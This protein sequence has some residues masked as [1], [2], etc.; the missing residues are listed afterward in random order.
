MFPR[1]DPKIYPIDDD[2]QFAYELLAEEKVLIVQGTGF[3]WP[4]PDHFRVV[5]LPNSDDLTDAIGRIATLPRALPQAPLAS[6]S[7]H[8]ERDAHE[9][10]P[11]RPARHRHRRQRHLRRAAAQPGGDPAPRRARASASRMV[12]D[13]DTRARARASS[14]TR[15]E[16]VD[17][18]ARGDR[19]SRHRHRRRADRRHRASRARWCSRRSPHGK[20]VVTANKALLA[21]HGNEIFAAARAK[22]VMVAFEA[23][24]AGGIPIIKALREGLT[25]NRIEWI[26][27]IINGTI[28]LHPVGD[29]RQG[30]STSTTCSN[31]A[32]ALRLRRGR[33]DVRHRGHRRRAQA[34]DHVARSPSACR[35]SSTRRTPKASSKLHA[36][37]HP[38]RRAARLPHQAARHH[39]ARATSGH[40]AARASDADPGAS[41]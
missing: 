10:D 29:A 21:V 12:A 38:L 7:R 16:V 40:R 28:E 6:T 14:A 24:V 5:F 26:A 30:R 31:E 18:R 36:R 17:R 4:T 41:A 1:L 13:L 19:Q 11:G 32:Q 8:A 9:A 22:G 27:G 34:D 2:Q 25:A 33:P 37:R 23:A 39:A 35:C 15:R 3:N 20:H